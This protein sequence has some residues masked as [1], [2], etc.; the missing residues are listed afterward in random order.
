MKKMELS[1]ESLAV[2][3][4]AV[5]GGVEQPRGTVMA[6]GFVPNTRSHSCAR[7]ACCPETTLC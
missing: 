4:F 5:D 3:S 1:L 6:N 2:D 7:T